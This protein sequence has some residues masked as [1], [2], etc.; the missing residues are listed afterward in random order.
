MSSNRS[1]TRQVIVS[2]AM[3]AGFLVIL[4]R[5]FN[6]QILQ[7]G[8]LSILAGNQHQKIV[9]LEGARG[10]IYDAH[11]HVLAMNVDVPSVFGEPTKLNNPSRLA[12]TIAPIL[13]VNRREL[14]SKLK[15]KRQFVWLARKLDPERGRRLERLPLKGIGMVLEGRRYYPKGYA[16]SHVLGFAG[17]DNQGLEGLEHQYEPYLRGKKHMVVLN[18]DNRGRTVFPEELPG[19]HP[20]AG[21]DMTLTIDEVIQ[22]IAEKELNRIVTETKARGGTIIIMEPRTG[23]ILAMALNPRFDPNRRG[24]LRP[25]HWRNRALTDV[26][27]PGSTMKIFL[28]AAAIEEG[29]VTPRTLVYGE[30]GRIRVAKTFIHD[31]DPSGWMTFAQVIE[32]SSNVGAVKISQ[33]LGGERYYRYL[34]EFGFGSRTQIDLPGESRGLLP[35]LDQ[36]D[37][38][39]LASLSIGQGLSVTSI[40]L[41]TAT[42]AIANGGLLMQ[43]YI[44]SSVRDEYGNIVLR[45][46]PKTVRRV[47][48]T[49]TVDQLTPILEGVITKGTGR[50]AAVPGY[51]AAGKTGTAQK[52]DPE[53]KAYSREHLLTSFVGYLPI[54]DPRV[55]ICVV[56]DEPKTEVWGGTVAAPVFRRV[57]E[58][59][60]PHLGITFQ[61]PIEIA[62]AGSSID[63]PSIQ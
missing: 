37:P 19:Q 12:R 25:E 13:K 3:M 26:Y 20:M 39:T 45:K 44:V 38:R 56:V 4:F 62:Y 31:H 15:Q 30:E 7:A 60:L 28:A 63:G 43:P 5:L 57:A 61:T 49:Q 1:R 6:L 9:E 18:L 54:D 47:V 24:G 17:T 40:Q 42:S 21:H 16:L 51:R 22:Y 53:T 14:E 2:M 34:K 23:A 33:A 52:V 10:T 59:V 11:G 41:A 29:V 46:G 55:T 48:S 32:R 35:A 27:D 8:E 36:W 50:R 58:Q